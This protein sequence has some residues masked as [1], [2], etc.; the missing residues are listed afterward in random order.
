M[1]AP[2]KLKTLLAFCCL[3]TFAALPVNPAS[4]ELF[5]NAAQMAVIY[6]YSNNGT[7]QS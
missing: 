2:M 6:G 5:S 3:V 4:G 7:I 1:E